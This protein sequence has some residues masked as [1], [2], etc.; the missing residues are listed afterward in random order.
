MPRPRFRSSFS[1]QLSFLPML[2][3]PFLTTVSTTR[4][5]SAKATEK[6]RKKKPAP[7]NRREEIKERVGSHASREISFLRRE[8]FVAR[9]K[10]PCEGFSVRYR[11]GKTQKRFS[12][13]QARDCRNAMCHVFFEKK[14]KNMHLI[15]RRQN[16]RLR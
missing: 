7:R 11:G 16:L 5:L 9:H 1:Q 10:A 14:K 6:E 15:A 4:S 13:A 8:K 12:R 2:L 3:F